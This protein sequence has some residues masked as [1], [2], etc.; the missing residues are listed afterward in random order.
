MKKLSISKRRAAVNLVLVFALMVAVGLGVRNNASYA[1][2]CSGDSLNF[3]PATGSYKV[4]DTINLNIQ[5]NSSDGVNAV[6]SPITY[7]SSELQ[8]NSDTTASPYSENPNNTD[9]GSGGALNIERA[10]LGGSTTGTQTI[11]TVSFTVTSVGSGSATIA[12]NDSSASIVSASTNQNV[13]PSGNCASSSPTATFSL[14][15]ASTGSGGGTGGTGG[16]TGSSGGGA[17]P[18]PAPT[19]T[20]TK[21]SSVV[22]TPSSSAGT[23]GVNVPSNTSVAVTKPVSVEPATV[24]TNGVIKVEYFLKGKLV[25]TETKAPYK[26]NI[27]VNNYKNGTYQLVSKTFYTNG[28]VKQTS[29]NLIIKNSADHSSIIIYLIVICIIVLIII[30]AN[31]F[32]PTIGDH[33]NHLLGHNNPPLGTIG[34]GQSNVV[35]GGGIKAEHQDYLHNQPVHEAPTPPNNGTSVPSTP[36]PITVN[37]DN[38][39]N[40]H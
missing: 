21:S 40:P 33:L 30:G 19:K 14:A 10:D 1:T 18:A 20:N 4:G 24:D 15:A 12:F 17:N 13:M 34:A 28:L 32:G 9:S 38:P 7:P 39:S 3:S 27:N 37:H 8:Y 36:K 16:S 26:Y 6:E 5:V 31:I 25:D 29:Q 22:V 2:S 11:T 23:T 35:I